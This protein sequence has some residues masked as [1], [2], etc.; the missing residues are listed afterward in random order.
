MPG[1]VDSPTNANGNSPKDIPGSSG[2]EDYKAEAAKRRQQDDNEEDDR[3]AKQQRSMPKIFNASS[4][5]AKCMPA[6][7]RAPQ[8]PKSAKHK[9]RWH[10]DKHDDD[11]DWGDHWKGSKWPE[12]KK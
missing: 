11:D 8:P 10:E 1:K 2:G 3:K 4:P 7:K 5:C 9:D 6:V 12:K